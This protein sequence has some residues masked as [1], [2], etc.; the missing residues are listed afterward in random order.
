MASHSY[1][2]LALTLAYAAFLIHNNDAYSWLSVLR[3]SV[4][5]IILSAVFALAY[6][7]LGVHKYLGF[8]QIQEPAFH[9]KFLF[10]TM[11]V[12]LLWSLGQSCLQMTLGAAITW[13]Q[14]GKEY[15]LWE[16]DPKYQFLPKLTNTS[17][18]LI[19]AF[20]VFFTIDF[21]RYWAHRLGHMG[22]LYKTFP[23]AHFQHHNQM[24]L[25]P[26]LSLMSPLAHIAAWATFIPFSFYWLQ[27]WHKACIWA[28]YLVHF[29]S[30]TQHLGFDPFP[31]LTWANYRLFFGILPWIP[32]YHQYHHTPFIRP[33]NYGNTSCFFDH[34]YNTLQPEF[35]EHMETGRMPAKL[36]AKIHD[37]SAKF[38]SMLEAKLRNKNKFDLNAEGKSIFNFEYE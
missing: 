27:G 35:V 20:L 22:F 9:L 24:F 12:V 34:F 32:L 30:F 33:G 13:P 36:W 6:Y 14:E 38:E 23:F 26:T 29:S 28:S 21:F 7:F 8:F 31:W 4:S 15:M 3:L 2:T 37:D 25:N 18:N 19:G 10:K 17:Q 5:T 11:W 1:V 16:L